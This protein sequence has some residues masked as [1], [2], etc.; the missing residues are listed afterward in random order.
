VVGRAAGTDYV[1]LPSNGPLAGTLVDPSGEVEG[2]R[3]LNE[4]LYQHVT[5]YF[6]L[7]QV[8]ALLDLRDASGNPLF[9]PPTP[10]SQ[11]PRGIG[12]AA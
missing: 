1:Q 7:L 5:A 8:Q 11:L 12:A 10:L 9:H 6:Y 3:F 4:A 2:V